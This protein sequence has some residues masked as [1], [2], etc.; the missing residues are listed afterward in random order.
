[1]SKISWCRK[2]KDGIKIHDPN[3]N[4]SQE[5]YKNAEESLKVL[6]SIKETQSN[7]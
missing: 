5:Y 3:D 7:M 4:L 2:Q 6:R 1:M